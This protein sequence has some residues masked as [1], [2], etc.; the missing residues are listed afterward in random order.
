MLQIVPVVSHRLPTDLKHSLH[1]ILLI[2]AK[3]NKL[4]KEIEVQVSFLL[5]HKISLIPRQ[6]ITLILC[7]TTSACVT[8]KPT[9]RADRIKDR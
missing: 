9:F 3:E 1:S 2:E 7:L 6:L 4:R 8:Q 5:H